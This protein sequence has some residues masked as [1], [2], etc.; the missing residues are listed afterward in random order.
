MN[1]SGLINAVLRPS[2]SNPLQYLPPLILDAINSSSEEC[3]PFKITG[4]NASY[5]KSGAVEGVKIA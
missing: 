5:C 1:A 3:S 4:P 2:T